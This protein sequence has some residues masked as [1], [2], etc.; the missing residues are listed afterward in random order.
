MCTCLTSC[1]S[2]LQNSTMSFVTTINR[3]KRGRGERTGELF[4]LFSSATPSTNIL[5]VSFIFLKVGGGRAQAVVS[6]TPIKERRPWT[7]PLQSAR[8]ASFSRRGGGLATK[9]TA[10]AVEVEAEVEMDAAMVVTV[11]SAKTVAV[12]GHGRGNS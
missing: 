2:L 10:V 8:C 6:S 5:S 3:D 7:W 12:G 9:S 4:C 1:T 11:A